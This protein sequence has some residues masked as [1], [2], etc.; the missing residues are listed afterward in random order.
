MWTEHQIIFL[1]ATVIG[2]MLVGLWIGWES[3]GKQLGRTERY[4]QALEAKRLSERIDIQSIKY[5]IKKASEENSRVPGW[6]AALSSI[7]EKIAL[8]ESEDAAQTVQGA[9][10]TAQV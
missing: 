9:G 4:L 8:M 2:S 10:D 1:M 3:W 7:Q 5:M 6:Y